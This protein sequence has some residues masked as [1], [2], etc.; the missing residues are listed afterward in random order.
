VDH[1]NWVDDVLPT[2]KKDNNN[3]IIPFLK[4]LFILSLSALRVSST[5]LRELQTFNLFHYTFMQRVLKIMC[6]LKYEIVYLCLGVWDWMIV[7]LKYKNGKKLPEVVCVAGWVGGMV[8]I[9]FFLTG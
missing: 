6:K 1:V 2:G 7:R 4:F 8:K 9:I 5:T 3:Q